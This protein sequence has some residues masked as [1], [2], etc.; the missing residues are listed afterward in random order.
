MSGNDLAADG[1]IDP[2]AVADT[3]AVLLTVLNSMATRSRRQQA[4]VGAAIAGAQ[5][6]ADPTEVGAALKLLLAERCITRPISLDDG[7]LIVTVLRHTMPRPGG[8]RFWLPD[9]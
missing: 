7:G 2:A 1:K 3:A 8:P 4:D 5:L 6:D 9:P